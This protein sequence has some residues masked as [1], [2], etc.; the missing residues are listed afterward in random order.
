M[1]SSKEPTEESTVESTPE[2]L[3]WNNVSLSIPQ[4]V[5]KSGCTTVLHGLSGSIRAGQIGLVLG[6][7]GSGKTSFFD[8]LTGHRAH[9]SKAQI[10]GTFSLNG[11]PLTPS[12]IENRRKFAYA[13][14]GD[15]LDEWQL[16]HLAEL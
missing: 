13:I 14:D 4:G 6:A 11:V 2:T 1:S 16:A 5:G 12:A 9:C 3:S 8:I 10:R 7:S 15:P